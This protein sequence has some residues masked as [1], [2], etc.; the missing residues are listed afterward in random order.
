MIG[1]ENQQKLQAEQQQSNG[2]MLSR[3]VKP[4]I[5]GGLLYYAMMN[6]EYLFGSST[7]ESIEQGA[8]RLANDGAKEQTDVTK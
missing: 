4:V 3:F 6:S 1:K 2:G 5:A 7:A 8:S